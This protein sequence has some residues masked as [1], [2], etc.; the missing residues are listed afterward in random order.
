MNKRWIYAV[1]P[2]S[3]AI[4]VLGLYLA[5][6]DLGIWVLYRNFMDFKRGE[7]LLYRED[8]TKSSA[9]QNHRSV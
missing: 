4:A 2:G 6:I 7:K 9:F 1:L 5:K 3:F 8:Q